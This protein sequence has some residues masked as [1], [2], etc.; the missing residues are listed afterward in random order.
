MKA[1][2]DA[3]RTLPDALG[4]ISAPGDVTSWN[5]LSGQ[6]IK[7]AFATGKVFVESRRHPIS[8]TEAFRSMG[9][10]IGLHYSAKKPAQ[11]LAVLETRYLNKRVAHPF[12]KK[13]RDLAKEIVDL[14]WDEHVRPEWKRPES[15]SDADLDLALDVLLKDARAKGYAERF[16]GTGGWDG[17]DGR[18][19]RFHLKSIFKPKLRPDLY[20]VGQGIS[21]WS[22]HCLA[23]F[24]NV[25][26]VLTSM[27]VKIEKDYVV[28][29]SYWT[30]DQFV[31]Y[32]N[33]VF[34]GVP[35]PAPF[36]VTDGEMFDACQNHFTQEIEPQAPRH[37]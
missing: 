3:Y 35:G 2:Y 30:E 7:G 20:K 37:L 27:S 8:L 16:A 19:V 23:T 21:A 13:A 18:I 22:V 24:C 32:L 29:D 5:E 10:G 17:P 9:C 36:G 25:F 26:I 34:A 31:K 28:T 15:F 6:F 1:T 14:W 4:P 33:Q 12:D 11:T